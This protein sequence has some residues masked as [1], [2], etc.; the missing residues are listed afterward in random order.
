MKTFLKTI[1]VSSLLIASLNVLQAQQLDVEVMERADDGLD[2]CAYGQVAGL[3]ADGDGFLFV[4]RG[5][6]TTYDS[7][8]ELKNNDK[9]WLFE[10]K[11]GWYGIVYGVDD[12]NCSP[13]EKDRPVDTIGKKGWVYGKWI[14]VLA[15]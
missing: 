9:V 12:Q 6:G 15:G 8:D 3:R 7:F 11:D 14:E 13:V 2:T 10:E 1:L 4:R 5:P